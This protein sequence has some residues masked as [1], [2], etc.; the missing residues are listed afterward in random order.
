M[1]QVNNIR[2]DVPAVPLHM[3]MLMK[4]YN[5][6]HN[7]ICTKTHLKTYRKIINFII[8]VK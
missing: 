3:L 5:V 6:S 1:I 2:D 8:V 7:T 4:L